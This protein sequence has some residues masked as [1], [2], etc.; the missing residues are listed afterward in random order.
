MS[1]ALEKQSTVVSQELSNDLQS[2]F[3]G[4]DSENVPNFMKLFWDEQQKYVKS[5]S[6]SS[7][8]YHPMIIKFCL[9]L[10]SKSSSAYSELRYNSKT[11]SGML[12][13]PS[14]RT[15]RDYRN[16]IRPTRGF[17]L[18]LLM[19]SQRKLLLFLILNDMLP[20]YLMK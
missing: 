14:L 1:D 7:I 13:L 17:L 12:V 8:K 3:C 19:S 10:A 18:L 6:A 2:I 11:G 16:Y 9:N 15:L 20:S 5:S 4:C